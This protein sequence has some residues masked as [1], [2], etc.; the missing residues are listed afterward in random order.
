MLAES[1]MFLRSRASRAR[2]LGADMWEALATTSKAR[3]CRVLAYVRH[4]FVKIAM[5]TKNIVTTTDCKRLGSKEL[6]Q[7][8]GECDALLAEARQCCRGPLKPP[9]K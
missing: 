1:E 3:D 7:K 8:A 4:A 9:T 2:S 6:A 5:T